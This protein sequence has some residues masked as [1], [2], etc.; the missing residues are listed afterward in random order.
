MSIISA[1]ICNQGGTPDILAAA[2][3]V[4]M[5]WNH[6]K[7]PYFSIPPT[8]HPSSIPSTIAGGGSEHIAPGA[9][10]VG[11]A[12]IV[13]EFSKPFELAGLFGTADAGAFD[14]E[15]TT[16]VDM[17]EDMAASGGPDMI[18]DEAAT[19]IPQ[20]RRRTPSLEKEQAPS[21]TQTQT[22]DAP[23]ARMP[24]RFRR[25]K[26]LSAYEEAASRSHPL[27]KKIL[28]KDARRARRAAAKL[29]N[30]MGQD[31]SM[32]VDDLRDTFIAG[33][34]ASEET[35]ASMT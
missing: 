34:G 13:S 16:E 9:E 7:I 25:A 11:Q 6:Q 27:H 18:V 32:E 2:R 20:K 19:S 22:F 15:P 8:V 24:K 4:L 31:A 33:I 12:Q 17:A 21:Q 26:D 30:G 3:Q 10:T 14:N 35:L 23:A 5:D 1:L 29:R 28:K